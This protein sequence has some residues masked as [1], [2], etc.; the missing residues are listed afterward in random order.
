MAKMNIGIDGRMRE[1]ESDET[2]SKTFTATFETPSGREVLK[3]LRSVTIEMVNG[4]NISDTELRHMEGQRF[5]VGLIETRIA[6]GHRSN[7]NA[8]EPS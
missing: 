8:R 3:H 7:T 2:I 1:R 6:H 4:P 5:L